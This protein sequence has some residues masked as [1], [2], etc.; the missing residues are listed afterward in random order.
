MNVSEFLTA[1]TTHYNALVR[2]YAHQLSLTFSQAFLLLNLPHDGAQMSNLAHKLG[3]DNST[4][5]RNIS[6]LEL[7]NCIVKKKEPKDKRVVNI[8]I[9]EDGKKKVYLL[10]KYFH[11]LN[12]SLLEYIDIEDQTIISEALEKLLWA[13]DCNRQK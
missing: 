1:L 10:E 2:T 8:H 6:K 13:M 3:I 9:T 12:S 7:L 4:L 11:D 5:T